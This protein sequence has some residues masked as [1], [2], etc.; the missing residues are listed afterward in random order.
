MLLKFD[1]A[2]LVDSTVC[3][4][5][6]IVVKKTVGTLIVVVSVTVDSEVVQTVVVG[7][8]EATLG[9]VYVTIEKT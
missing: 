5:G 3:V 6:G 9:Q 7:V 4:D 2:Y 1:C 8:T